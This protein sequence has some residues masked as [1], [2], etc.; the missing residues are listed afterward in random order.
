VTSGGV[1]GTISKV[2]E[3][4]VVARVAQ[5]TELRFQKPSVIATLPK[6]TLKKLDAEKA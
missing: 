5:G 2:E 4:F 1:V 3:D 6:G